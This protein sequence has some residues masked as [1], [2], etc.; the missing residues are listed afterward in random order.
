MYGKLE[1]SRLREK[2]L[3]KKT[4]LAPSNLSSEDTNMRA[5]PST[6]SGQQNPVFCDCL[7]YF[8]QTSII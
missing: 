3:Q 2:I 6:C 5:A 7:K 1:G 8:S 4:S